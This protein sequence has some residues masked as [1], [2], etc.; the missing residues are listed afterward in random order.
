MHYAVPYISRHIF[1]TLR[2]RRGRPRTRR[3]YERR[4]LPLDLLQGHVA[5]TVLGTNLA[6]QLGPMVAAGGGGETIRNAGSRAGEAVR[7]R[8][9]AIGRCLFGDEGAKDRHACGD[10]GG[11]DFGH[12]PHCEVG[13]GVWS[14]GLEWVTR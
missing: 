7:S 14:V 6:T 3:L 11:G 13:S 8:A 10:D 2:I 1:S 12:A 5:A 9:G 4:R